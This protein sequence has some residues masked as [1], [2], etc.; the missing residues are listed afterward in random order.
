MINGDVHEPMV[1]WDGWNKVLLLCT[2]NGCWWDR[3]IPSSGATLAD[4][5]ILYRIEHSPTPHPRL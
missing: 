4:L 3:D 5:M 1:D 2:A